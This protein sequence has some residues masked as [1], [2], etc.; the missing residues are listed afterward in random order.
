MIEIAEIVIS[1]VLIVLILLQERSG[2]TSGIFGGVGGDSSYQTRRGL[3][4]GIFIATIV[5]AVLFAALAV[6]K[7][8]IS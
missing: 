2:G 7:L 8:L 3:E 5:C 1:I 4:K 6:V